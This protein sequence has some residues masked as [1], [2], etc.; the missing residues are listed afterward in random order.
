LTW[1]QMASVDLPLHMH[2]HAH[3]CILIA[4]TQ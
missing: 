3:T 4:N 2:R 1:G